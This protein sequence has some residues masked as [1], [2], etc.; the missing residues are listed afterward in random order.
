MKYLGALGRDRFLDKRPPDVVFKVDPI[1]E[2][3]VELLIDLRDSVCDVF[4][5]CVE[6]EQI[7]RFT[8]ILGHLSVCC[9]PCSNILAH[10]PVNLG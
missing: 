3:V 7:S 2:N 8:P 6:K 5:S 1:V 4:L 10:Q 9:V